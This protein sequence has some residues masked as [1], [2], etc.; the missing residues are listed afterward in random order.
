MT[1]GDTVRFTAVLTDPDGIDDLIGGALMTG[2]EQT[3][4]GAFVTSGQ[5]GSYS[6][7]LSWDE[8]NQSYDITFAAS[9]TREFRAVFLTKPATVLPVIQA[10]A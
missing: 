8:L 5:E 7:V 4:L 9:E 3:Q 1:E 10:C 6:L 2:D